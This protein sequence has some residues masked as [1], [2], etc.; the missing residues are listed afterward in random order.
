VTDVCFRRAAVGDEMRAPV[1]IKP[2]LAGIRGRWC[3][4][5]WRCIPRNATPLHRPAPVRPAPVPAAPV[6]AA[7]V[8]AAP[9]PGASRFVSAHP[10]PDKSIPAKLAPA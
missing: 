4:C 7:L 8:R 5:G 1:T 9:V 2:K 10:S 3:C 6:P